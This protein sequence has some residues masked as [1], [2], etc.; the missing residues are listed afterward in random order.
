MFAILEMIYY[1]HTMAFDVRL[2]T[3]MTVFISVVETGS[4][5][6]AGA[7]LGLTQSGVSRSIQRLEERLGARLLVRS[8][9]SVTLTGEG[10]RFY[11]EVKPL[12]GR[13]EE[14][15]DK[16]VGASSSIRGLLRI[17]VDATFARLVLAHQIESFLDSHLD[18]SVEICARTEV[19]DLIGEGFDLALRFGNPTPSRLVAKR[20][21]Q[22]RVL[23]CASPEYVK[24]KGCPRRPGDLKNN[25]HEC[26]L[27]RDPVTRRPFPWEFHHGSKVISVPVSGR[28]TFDDGMSHLAACVAGCGV[29]QVFELGIADHLRSKRLLN[30]F[31]N[32]SDE[33]F[34][35]YIYFPSSQYIPAK[36]RAFEAFVVGAIPKL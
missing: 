28:L 13:L 16:T 29:A 30:L 24:R 8:P 23:S 15:A 18:L 26:I 10:R 25:S 14:T 22:V 7:S 1:H 31:P 12:L 9:R 35:L 20:I 34:P 36:V 5:V 32:W 21:A 17:N 27:F 19:G 4:F 2:L 11:E 6:G 33:N 3:G